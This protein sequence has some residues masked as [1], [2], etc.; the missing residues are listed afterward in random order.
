MLNRIIIGTTSGLYTAARIGLLGNNKV[1]LKDEN[2]TLDTNKT[3]RYECISVANLTIID[4]G[5]YFDDDYIYE[6][7]FNEVWTWSLRPLV[8]E[9]I[10]IGGNVNIHD[11][12]TEYTSAGHF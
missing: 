3:L 1:V 5:H 7:R 8:I 12:L 9:H 11:R 10:D 4:A 2:D 6:K